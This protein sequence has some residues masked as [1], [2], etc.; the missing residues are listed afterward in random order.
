M[1]HPMRIS[2]I[3]V[4]VHR[5]RTKP[6]A[7]TS[8]SGIGLVRY[9][10]FD[11]KIQRNDQSVSL[12][13]DD[14]V[15]GF[16]QTKLI[17]QSVDVLFT[18]QF[19]GHFVAQ[20]RFVLIILLN[21]VATK[22]KFFQSGQMRLNYHNIIGKKNHPYPQ[23]TSCSTPSTR[24]F[25]SKVFCPICRPR[26]TTWSLLSAWRPA[27]LCPQTR[28][29]WNGETSIGSIARGRRVS[30]TKRYNTLRVRTLTKSWVGSGR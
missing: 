12:P 8:V 11:A 18:D 26:P 10:A 23:T 3:H 21:P 7:F 29:C 1:T 22:R 2:L 30:H 25:P 24:F 13:V 28:T 4:H 5:G 20:Q 17:A 19:V 15:V 9:F 27:H 14:G 16:R 6:S